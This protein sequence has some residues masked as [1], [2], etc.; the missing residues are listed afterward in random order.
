MPDV[1]S[2]AQI[3]RNVRS[4][5]ETTENYSLGYRINMRA[6]HSNSVGL[7]VSKRHSLVRFDSGC[8]A[9]DH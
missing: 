5:N 2:P 4:K 1:G 8:C 7:S 3:T 9:P 6:L